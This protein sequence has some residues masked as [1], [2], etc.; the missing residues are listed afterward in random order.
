MP[1]WETLDDEW[2]L[3]HW[4]DMSVSKASEY[5]PRVKWI[6]D[7]TLS[8]NGRAALE[9]LHSTY[10]E[11]GLHKCTHTYTFSLCACDVHKSIMSNLKWVSSLLCFTWYYIYIQHIYLCLSTHSHTHTKCC[12]NVWEL[13]LNW[14]FPIVVACYCCLIRLTK[15]ER[16]K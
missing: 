8:Q 16:K 11:I 13:I 3:T 1:V 15:K 9:E 2:A 5:C 4:H 10:T 6:A 7:W 12:A 14:L